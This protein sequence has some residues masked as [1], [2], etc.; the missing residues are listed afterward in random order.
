[1][2]RGAIN[3]TSRR[4]MGVSSTR[5]AFYLIVSAILV[6]GFMKRTSKFRGERQAYLTREPPESITVR[7]KYEIEFMPM[8]NYNASVGGGIRASHN[9]SA[10]NGHGSLRKNNDDPLVLSGART[11]NKDGKV[12]LDFFVAGFPKCGTT[13]LQEGLGAH[14]EIEMPESETNVLTTPGTDDVIYEKMME[15][16][17]PLVS[18]NNRNVKYGIKNPIGLGRGANSLR[19][20]QRLRTLFPD[21]K[22]VIGLRHPVLYLQSFYNYRVMNHYRGDGIT[23]DKIPPLESLLS[24]P[25]ASA[26]VESARFEKILQNLG[27]TM[28]SDSS[29]TSPNPVFLYTIDQLQDGNKTRK[30]A[31]R[32][33]LG[34]YLELVN[35]IPPLPHSNKYNVVFNET[36]NICDTKY[37]HIREILIENGRETQ[38]W[39]LEEFMQS[40]DVTVANEEH[41]CESMQSFG[42]DPCEEGTH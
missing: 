3:D 17:L 21:T 4:C 42:S 8:K 31:F 27:K 9:H 32:D 35:P 11:D 33:A 41:F 10:S 6:S 15:E 24:K 40:P 38:Q 14:S 16:L 34:V 12:S 13:S 7:N 28:P 26:S 19:A 23:G 29:S 18:K 36:I 37:D 22:L 1:M 25:W 2:S 39:I 20:V 5:A 30:E